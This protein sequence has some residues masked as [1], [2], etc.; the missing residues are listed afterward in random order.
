MGKN[1]GKISK[2]KAYC[3]KIYTTVLKLQR[4]K[5]ENDYH[6]NAFCGEGMGHI[7]GFCSGW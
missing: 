3:L 6:K 5:P 1:G 4:K 2:T 7:K